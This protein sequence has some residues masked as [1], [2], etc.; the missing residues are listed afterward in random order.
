[1]QMERSF[2]SRLEDMKSRL[3]ASHSTNRTMHNYVR[4]LKSAYTNAFNDSTLALNVSP[5]R[6]ALF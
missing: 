6:T 4:F 3:E 5:P 2:G 1:M